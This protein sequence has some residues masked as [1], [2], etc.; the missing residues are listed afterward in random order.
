MNCCNNCE[1]TA[2][3]II[4]ITDANTINLLQ[5]SFKVR[6]HAIQFLQDDGKGA[7]VARNKGLELSTGEVVV[8]LDD[9]VVV[10]SKW[11]QNILKPYKNPSIG[12]VGGRVEE[13]TANFVERVKQR[14]LD[15]LA[16][17]YSHSIGKVMIDGTVVGNFGA[18]KRASVDHLYGCNMS[19]RKACLIQIGGFDPAFEVNFREETDLSIRVRKM[20]LKLFFEPEALLFHK[21][22]TTGGGIKSL[23]RT[24]KIY[25]SFKYHA[26]VYFKH[27]YKENR[28]FLPIFFA[29]NIVHLFFSGAFYHSPYIILFGVR[30]FRDGYKLSLR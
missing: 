20:G 28:L 4:V 18:D 26:Y 3:Q 11:G 13:P 21:K 5:P 30:A 6:T 15:V 19:F 23:D 24:E 12:G 27:V 16:F 8:F 1:G 9:D 17:P 7:A 25:D 2:F 14:F 29:K 22:V 10:S